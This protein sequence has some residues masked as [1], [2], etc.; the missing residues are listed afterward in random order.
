[1]RVIGSLRGRLL[2]AGVAGVLLAALASALL[3]GAAFERAAQRAFDRSL[4][5]DLDTLIGLAEVAPDGRIVLRREPGGER[6]DRVFSGWYWAVGEGSA[7]RHSR[8]FWDSADLVVDVPPADGARIYSSTDG[9]RGQR[10][11]VAGQRVRF[12]GSAQPQVFAVAGDLSQV[13]DEVRD[14]RVLAAIAVAIIA[15][16]LLIVIGVQVQFGLRPFQ[17]LAGTLARIR[18]GEDLRFADAALPREIAPLAEQIDVLLD[19]HA[20]RV[21]R[22]RHAAQDLAHAL[23]TPLAVLAADSERDV[24]DLATHVAA[25]VARMRTAIE[26]HLAGNLSADGRQRTPVASV[27]AA[28]LDVLQR[29]HATRGLHFASDIAPDAVFAGSTED[30]EEML[31]NLLDNAC[32]WAGTK[33]SIGADVQGDRLHIRIDDD[34]PGM[35]A[36][37]ASRAVARGVCLDERTS[38]SGLG[39]DIVSGV[40]ASYGGELVLD[41][42]A[43]GGLRSTL[44]LPAAAS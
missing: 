32:K 40:A 6:Y 19:E 42:A 22:A 4:D 8:S 38:G 24:P 3:L 2:L 41:R 37:A 18:R 44:R 25:Q 29:V 16:S 1:V 43:T 5:V 12:A 9:P 17:R 30:L 31:G 27:V 36:D 20:R 21:Q 23:K 7:T 35:D 15:A 13:R 14:F 11:R 10:L 34:G 33:V 28:L 26:R 39:L